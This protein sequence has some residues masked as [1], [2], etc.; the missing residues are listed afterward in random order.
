MKSKFI[1]FEGGEGSG[2]TV[3]SKL[4]YEYLLSIGIK[5][6]HTREPG[7]TKFAEDIRKKLKKKNILPIS[8]LLLIL[9][10]RYDHVTQIIKPAL[11][12]GKWVICDRFVDST[13]CY[14]GIMQN[15][16]VDTVAKWHNEVTTDLWPDLTYL[17]DAPASITAERL[18]LRSVSEDKYDSLSLNQHEEIRNGFLKLAKKF[19][20]RFITISGNNNISEIHSV[21]LEKMDKLSWFEATL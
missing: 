15:L 14:Q 20:N 8:E 11:E 13:L 9:S 7:G 1:S 4:L 19:S 10:A 5:C 3:Q 18:N 21:I 2:K 12:K 16:T 17:L 6:I